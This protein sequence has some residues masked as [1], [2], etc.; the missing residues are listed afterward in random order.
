MIAIDSATGGN[1]CCIAHG[2]DHTAG[3]SKLPLI[4]IILS[5]KHA[6]QPAACGLPRSAQA[7]SQCIRGIGRINEDRKI[8]AAHDPLHAPRE[9]IH[10]F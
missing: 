9:P 4:K 5:A 2:A 10:G 7:N 3:R 8:L 1:H 6:N